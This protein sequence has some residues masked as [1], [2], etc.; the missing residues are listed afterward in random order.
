MSKLPPFR[1]E[2][3]LRY[4]KRRARSKSLTAW[5][6][7]RSGTGEPGVPLEPTRKAASVISS[8]KARG[9]AERW[10]AQQCGAGMPSNLDSYR[11][12]RG[13]L[14]AAGKKSHLA[15]QAE[16]FPEKV[17]GILRKEYGAK[18]ASILKGIPAF[19]DAYQPWYS[20]ARALIRQLLP[21]RLSDFVGHYERPRHRKDLS[22]ENYRI[23][24]YLQGLRATLRGSPV[25]GP[26][27][28]IPQFRQQLA[29]LKSVE[30]RFQSALFD[31]KQLVRADLFDSELDAAKELAEHGFVRAA[32]ALAG[33]ALEKHL[34]QVCDNH[35]VRVAKKA[36][37]ISDLNNALKGAGVI[38]TP[39]WRSLQHLADIRNLCDH[40]RKS[41]PTAEQVEDLLMG[42]SKAI[43]TLF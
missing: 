21:D 5:G 39:R 8:A 25:V 14:V 1:A 3:N 37:V 18:A 20:E 9:P 2:V 17:R 7:T 31:I 38:D 10:A 12:D 43:K 13:S 15:I 16:C 30:A 29:I 23:V 35:K 24:D 40:N 28:G 26:E 32:G 11:K 33:V 19:A 6:P 42:V 34:A 4:G 41:E 36:P 22:Y 27:A